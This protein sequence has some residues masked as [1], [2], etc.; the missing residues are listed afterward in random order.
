MNITKGLKVGSL[1][2]SKANNKVVRLVELNQKLRIATIKHHAQDHL[3][4]SEVFISD[5]IKA[6]GEQVKAYFAR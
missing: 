2:H 1:Y 6:T 3:F 4:E 5:L